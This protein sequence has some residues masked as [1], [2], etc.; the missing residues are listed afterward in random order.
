MGILA[1]MPND[2][3]D[4]VTTELTDRREQVRLYQIAEEARRLETLSSHYLTFNEF[5]RD[6]MKLLRV[7]RIL[8]GPR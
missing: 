5:T 4:R 2:V 7:T 6:A 1:H 8:Q 3:F